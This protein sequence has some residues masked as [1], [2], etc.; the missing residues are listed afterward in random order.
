MPVDR[1]TGAS[2]A[3]MKRRGERGAG[4]GVQVDQVDGVPSPVRL[5]G[6]KA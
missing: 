4:A 3:N 6:T 1:T 5:I 2:L